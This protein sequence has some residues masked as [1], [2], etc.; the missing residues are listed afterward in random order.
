MELGRGDLEVEVFT[1]A[2]KIVLPRE[3]YLAEV[4]HMVSF[5]K[6]KNNGVTFYDPIN[7]KIDQTIDQTQFPTKDWSATPHGLH[8]DNVPSNA[9]TPRVACFTMRAFVDSDDS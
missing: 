4:F 3:G 9:P 1:M 6:S 8:K 7:P 2:S 5:L